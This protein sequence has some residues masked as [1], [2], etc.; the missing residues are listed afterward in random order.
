VRPFVLADDG[1][2]A[3]GAIPAQWPPIPF[4]V[5]SARAEQNRVAI[6]SLDRKTKKL[7]VPIRPWRVTLH[8]TPAAVRLQ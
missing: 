6:G 1:Y 2:L 4:Q 7:L 3:M 5:R 8:A